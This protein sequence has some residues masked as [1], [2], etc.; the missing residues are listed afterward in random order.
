M[1]IELAPSILPQSYRQDERQDVVPGDEAGEE[2]DG[3]ERRVDVPRPDASGQSGRRRGCLGHVADLR[4]RN[5][6]G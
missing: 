2:E 3:V 5:N 6:V 1:S 4:E